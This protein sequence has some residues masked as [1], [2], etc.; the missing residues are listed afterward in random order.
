MPDAA[1]QQPLNW[2]GSL[3]KTLADAPFNVQQN[4]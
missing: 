1:E 3:Q 4:T 2:Q